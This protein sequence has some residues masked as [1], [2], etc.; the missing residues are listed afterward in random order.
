MAADFGEFEFAEGFR[1]P[2]EFHPK[3]SRIESVEKNSFSKDLFRTSPGLVSFQTPVPEFGTGEEALG[4]LA[5]SVGV[6]HG[7]A[8][9]SEHVGDGDALASVTHQTV[10]NHSRMPGEAPSGVFRGNLS[11]PFRVGV[12]LVPEVAGFRRRGEDVLAVYAF[13]GFVFIPFV[14]PFLQPF[15]GKVPD[16]VGQ[17]RTLFVECPEPR[18]DVFRADAVVSRPFDAVRES[19][20]V[21][22]NPS[23]YRFHGFVRHSARVFEE[24]DP[25][26]PLVEEA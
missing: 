17:R 26:A 18:A 22:R 21:P 8:E 13:S 2:F 24:F 12:Y 10:G 15:G 25:E 16:V 1:V 7:D 19:R 23:A 3:R 20:P 5:Y 6:R 9:F 4:R 14:A 11:Q